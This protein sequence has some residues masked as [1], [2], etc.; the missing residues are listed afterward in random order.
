MKYVIVVDWIWS[1]SENSSHPMT[2]IFLTYHSISDKNI[3]QSG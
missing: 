3:V 2:L 1:W